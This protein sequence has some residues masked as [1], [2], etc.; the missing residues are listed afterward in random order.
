MALGP[1]CIL[2]GHMQVKWL[3]NFRNL[4]ANKEILRHFYQHATTDFI[5]QPNF[6]VCC[7]LVI[8]TSAFTQTFI[9]SDF[10]AT[11]KAL[12]HHTKSSGVLF[13]A[14]IKD[15]LLTMCYDEDS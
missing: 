5:I 1:W 13:R 2:L 4:L 8:N 12:R 3:V 14:E 9:A 7:V 15:V 11:A 10:C 6:Y